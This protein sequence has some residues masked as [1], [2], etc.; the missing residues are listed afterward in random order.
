[1][2]KRYRRRDSGWGDRGGQGLP[3]IVIRGLCTDQAQ[4]LVAGKFS[5]LALLW[6]TIPRATRQN[7]FDDLIRVA[8]FH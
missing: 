1:V 7:Q 2:G 6:G 3:I 5:R 8:Q 4:L